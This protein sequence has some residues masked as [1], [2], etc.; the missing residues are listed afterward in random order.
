MNKEILFYP[1]STPEFRIINGIKYIVDYSPCHCSCHSTGDIHFFAC[2]NNGWVECLRK[3]D[4][5]PID[6]GE[7]NEL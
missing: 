1:P 7:I 2:C 4:D 3:V 6:D 5:E